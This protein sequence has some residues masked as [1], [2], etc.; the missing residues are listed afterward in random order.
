[1]SR[2]EIKATMVYG[3]CRAEPSLAPAPGGLRKFE[4]RHEIMD[5]QADLEV[6][7]EG[8]RRITGFDMTGAMN[9]L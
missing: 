1:M 2:Q 7:V 5:L 3:A 8:G 6:D 9:R 4:K